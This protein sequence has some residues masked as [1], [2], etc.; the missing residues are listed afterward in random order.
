MVR[1]YA[2]LHECRPKGFRDTENV[3]LT[4]AGAHDHVELVVQF[5]PEIFD[6]RPQRIDEIVNLSVDTEHM[7]ASRSVTETF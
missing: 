7:P 4:Y 1:C 2:D 5:S 6:S 3:T